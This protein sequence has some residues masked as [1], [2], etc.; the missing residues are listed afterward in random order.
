MNLQSSN[1]LLVAKF[2]RAD[3][4]WQPLPTIIIVVVLG[5]ITYNIARFLIDY[6]NNPL[7]K[8]TTP[9]KEYNSSYKLDQLL[10]QN[11][12]YYKQLPS[13][14]KIEFR[15][16]TMQTANHFNWIAGSGQT[17]T[18]EMRL[19]ISA[20]AVQL[21]FGRPGAKQDYFSTIVVYEDKYFNPITKYH[22]KGEVN[23]HFIVLSYKHFIEGYANPNDKINLGLHEMA[24]ALDL[25]LFL[26]HSK[27]YFLRRL[28]DN[29]INKTYPD[30]VSMQHGND[31]FL[32]DYGK[33]NL[34]EFFAVAV[35]HFF[36]APNEMLEKKPILY[37]ELCLLLNQDPVAGLYRGVS[38]ERLK[39][40]ANNADMT[41]NYMEQS[42]FKS[43]SSSFLAIP[44]ILLLVSGIMFFNAAKQPI[45][46]ILIVVAGSLLAISFFWCRKYL[47]RVTIKN[48]HL[49]IGTP[50][51]KHPQSINLSNIIVVSFES[52]MSQFLLNI[53]YYENDNIK[54][55]SAKFHLGKTGL[56]NLCQFL[57]SKGLTVEVDGK[58]VTD[59]KDKG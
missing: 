14:F 42:V 59:T 34:R 12:Y 11:I 2:T 8:K 55:V 37:R 49:F 17:I 35:E 47:K 36:E 57:I 5:I 30:F 43:D 19:L 45:D 28:M 41:D 6:Y 39:H 44:I 33:Q 56:R 40:F 7:N 25:S 21:L 1:L 3:M 53:A 24:H 9:L 50:F 20:S 10:E 16:R 46:T 23:S 4:Q 27:Y 13:D 52:E 31:N 51:T 54:E 18:E 38:A 26:A 29:F 22:H 32:R 15:E 48:T 58:I